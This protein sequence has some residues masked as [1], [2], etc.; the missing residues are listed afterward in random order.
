M[1]MPQHGQTIVFAKVPVGS[2]CSPGVAY[3]VDRPKA[4]GAFRFER[5]AT[6]SSTY[7]QP[8]AVAQSEW[9]AA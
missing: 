8:W 2:Y 1:A 6:G 4:K 3:R 9:T 7:D 5:V